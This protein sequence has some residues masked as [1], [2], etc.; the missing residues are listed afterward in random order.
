MKIF[1]GIIA[2]I[3]LSISGVVS[4]ASIQFDYDIS[5][6]QTAPD[7]ASPWMT[8]VFEDGGSSGIVDLTITVGTVGIADVDEIY[9]N[10]NP[11]LNAT[12]LQISRTGGTGPTNAAINKAGGWNLGTN[13]FQADGDGIYDLWLELPPP[14]GQQAERFSAGET[15]VF[16][17][18][19]IGSLTADDFNYLAEPGG[20]NGPFYTAAHV[21][22]TGGGGSSDWIA[23]VPIPAAVWLFGSGLGLLGWFR[24]RQTA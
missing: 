14:P 12:Q 17:I 10:L 13:A 22:S 1:T 4:A 15:L 20:G 8:A 19:G 24:R 16:A 5:F 9:F 6:G 7:G 21:L 11:L 23:A 2:I 3:A 18:S